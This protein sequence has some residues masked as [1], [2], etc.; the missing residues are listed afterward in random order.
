MA[1]GAGECTPVGS[2]PDSPCERPPG[3]V[4]PATSPTRWAYYYQYDNNWTIH[5]TRTVSDP[6]GPQRSPPDRGR[7][8]LGVDDVRRWGAAAS[9]PVPL[10]PPRRAD[11]LDQGR[12]RSDQPSAGAAGAGVRVDAGRT[13]GPAVRG[14]PASGPGRAGTRASTSIHRTGRVS[15]R[16]NRAAILRQCAR[17]RPGWRMRPDPTPF[18]AGYVTSMH[19]RNVFPAAGQ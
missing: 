19:H 4:Y 18:R 16:P 7:D 12:R 3:R 1:R 5:G 10:P 2:G 8:R 13:R 9:I 17:G 15:G 11:G 6:P 14:P